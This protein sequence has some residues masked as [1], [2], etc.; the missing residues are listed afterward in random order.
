VFLS[1][2]L[3]PPPKWPDEKVAPRGKENVTPTMM[4]MCRNVNININTSG[5]ITTLIYAGSQ[6]KA[7]S[8]LFE[9]ETANAKHNS[10]TFGIKVPVLTRH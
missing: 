3:P 9:T 6:I 1:R 4:S 8:L 2:R 5:L 10:R 7:Q